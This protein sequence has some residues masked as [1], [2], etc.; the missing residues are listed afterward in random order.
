M[1]V[2][3]GRAL[4]VYAFCCA[5]WGSTWLVIKIGLADLP[6]FHFAAIRMAA[7]CL[8]MAPFAFRPGVAR[9]SRSERRLIALCGTLQIGIAYALV[10]AAEERIDSGLAAILFCTFP[11]WVG[12]LGHFLLPD[13]PLTRRT[14]AAALLGLAGVATI[15]APAI[16]GALRTGPGPLL[17]GGLCVLGSSVAAAVANVLNK[18]WFAQVSPERNVWGQTLSGG[19][20]LVL[21]ALGFER[22]A[23]IVWTTRA[24]LAVS[25]LA[26]VGTSMAFAGLFWLIP[27]VPVSVIGTIPLVDT[28]VAAALGAA[29]L[30]ERLPGRVIVGTLGIL[31]GVALTVAGRPRG[32]AEPGGHI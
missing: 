13:E 7:A 12:L 10:F 23:R 6:P 22:G 8:F 21:L 27:R 17:S 28:V 14:I 31:G 25:Y 1:R 4:A 20:L 30:G 3:S 5:V 11:I 29:V 2:L 9:P 15:E 18:R 24:V 19:A 16:A 26:L 32:R